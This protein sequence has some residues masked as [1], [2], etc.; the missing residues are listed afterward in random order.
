MPLGVN[1]GP[2]SVNKVPSS[3]NMNAA[4]RRRE[5]LPLH[6]AATIRGTHDDKSS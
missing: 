4:G 5:A 2:R 6:E 1:K 3:V